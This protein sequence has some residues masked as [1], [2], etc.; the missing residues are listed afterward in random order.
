MWSIGPVK[1]WP[2]LIEQHTGKPIDL[3]KT[4]VNDQDVIAFALAEKI[5]K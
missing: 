5:T 3:I 4:L 2:D 1:Y